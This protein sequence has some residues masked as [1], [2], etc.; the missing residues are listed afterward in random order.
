MYERGLILLLEDYFL[1]LLVIWYF[2]PTVKLFIVTQI[3][4]CVFS[5]LIFSRRLIPK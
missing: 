2:Y 4:V 5:W 3:I 1:W